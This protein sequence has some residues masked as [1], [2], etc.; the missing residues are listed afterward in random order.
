MK[1][2]SFSFFFRMSVCSSVCLLLLVTLFGSVQSQ[3][4]CITSLDRCRTNSWK[5]Y[6][7]IW[8]GT[9]PFQIILY[10]T[11]TF[12]FPWNITSG[13]NC[14][15]NSVRVPCLDVLIANLPCTKHLLSVLDVLIA[16]LPCT[17][18]L[19]SVR[20]LKRHILLLFEMKFSNFNYTST[21]VMLIYLITFY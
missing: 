7:A 13:F 19:L 12:I 17:K 10:L 21:M 8:N 3:G 20:F 2:F 6:M 18:H 5:P 16:N 14:C 11:C 9:L 15:Q 1:S 4:M